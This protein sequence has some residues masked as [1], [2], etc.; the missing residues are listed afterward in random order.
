M[1]LYYYSKLHGG[2]HSTVSSKIEMCRLKVLS[3]YN[4]ESTLKMDLGRLSEKERIKEAC[5][6]HT[7]LEP[8]LLRMKIIPLYLLTYLTKMIIT[9]VR[10][11]KTCSE[12]CILCA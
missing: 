5:V 3:V 1:N 6:L 10:S 11:K 9:L 8:M 12:N 7:R 2:D 4:V